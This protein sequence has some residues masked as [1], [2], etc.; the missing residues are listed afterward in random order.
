MKKNIHP[1]LNLV[2]L[3]LILTACA[4]DTQIA[5]PTS[6]QECRA[7]MEWKIDYSRS[8]GIA[9]HTRSVSVS[10]NGNMI[11]KDYG[12]ETEISQDELKKISGMLAEACPFK[13]GRISSGCADCFVY[14]MVI[15]MNDKRYSLE[16]NE[17]NIPK[18]SKPLIEYLESYLTK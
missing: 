18:E 7:P 3:S 14:K 12:A 4:S 2:L 11:M 8:G 16:T 13:I 17:L 6:S 5:Q 1:I 10:S 9:G 15:F